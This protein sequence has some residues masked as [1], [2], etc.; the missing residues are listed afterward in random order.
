MTNIMTPPAPSK[1]ASP[2]TIA[3]FAAMNASISQMNT[4][5]ADYINAQLA[6]QT[7]AAQAIESTPSNTAT[8]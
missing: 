6:D 8:P 1:G 5:I 2:A 4:A 3:A 7:A